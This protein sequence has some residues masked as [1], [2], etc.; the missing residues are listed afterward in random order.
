MLLRS[1]GDF[2]FDSDVYRLIQSGPMLGFM[3]NTY[4]FNAARLHMLAGDH[5][6]G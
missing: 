3:Q 2:L 6:N 1:N 4:Y 5:D